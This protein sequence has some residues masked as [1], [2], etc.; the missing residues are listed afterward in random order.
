MGVRVLWVHCILGF[1]LNAMIR[2]SPVYSRKKWAVKQQTMILYFLVCAPTLCSYIYL[3][4]LN[5]GVGPWGP[6]IVQ[7][8]TSARFGTNSTGELLTDQESALL[9]GILFG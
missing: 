7:K 4:S 5:R 6:G 8:Y 1:L 9:T 3:F 2:R